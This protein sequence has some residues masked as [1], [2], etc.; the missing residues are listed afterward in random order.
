[1]TDTLTRVEV[2]PRADVL[3]TAPFGLRADDGEGAG[4]GLTLDGWAA[5][6]NRKALIDSWEGKF[7]EQIANGSMKRSFRDAPPVVQ[8][9][10]GRHPL[11][12]SIPIARLT[13]IEESSDPTHAP[14]GGAHV[15]GRLHDNWLIEPV[16]D[17]IAAKAIKGMSFRFTVIREE[18]RDADGKVVKDEE[19]L[20]EL[21]RRTWYEEVPVEELLT[22]TLKELRVPELGPVVF[23]AYVETS[24]SVRSMLGRLD[25]AER[26]AIA[27]TLLD[28]QD[29]DVTGQP[30]ARSA[31][32]G[33]SDAE[34]GS[35]KA[36]KSPDEL[37]TLER[38]HK[39]L[40]VL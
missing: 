22:R 32:G 35:G 7:W 1:M 39:A 13:T 9:D 15:V 28:E 17:A 25:A 5:V 10:H 18:W 3:R 31:G 24:V 2:P 34:P 23:P 6:F 33:A 27:Q 19:K 38:V 11:V 29:T 14:D 30:D 37:R 40:G 12:G 36:P 26:R 20:R 16:R 8:F 4:D 21:L